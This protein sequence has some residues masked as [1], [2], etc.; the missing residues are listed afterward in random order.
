MTPPSASARPKAHHNMFYTY[1]LLSK[2][3]GRLYTGFTHDLRNRFKEHNEGKVFST[4]GRQPLK[5]IYY[6]ACMNE[7]DARAREKQLKTGKGK[8]YLKQR[9]KR[10]LLGTGLTGSP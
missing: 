4:K 5:L 8:K 2:K 10:F 9:L 1:V 7:M 6:E 3:D